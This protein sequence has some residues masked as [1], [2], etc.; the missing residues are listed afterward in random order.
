MAPTFCK[1]LLP[2][3]MHDGGSRRKQETAKGSGSG[4]IDLVLI[5]E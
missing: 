1:I 5:T 4:V 3:E 2:A